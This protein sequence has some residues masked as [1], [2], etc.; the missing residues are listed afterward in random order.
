MAKDTLLL[1]Y[2]DAFKGM[3][4]VLQVAAATTFFTANLSLILTVTQA[5]T[6]LGSQLASYDTSS[7]RRVLS[8]RGHRGAVFSR[9][10]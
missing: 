8:R 7:R 4:D 5:T 2:G 10:D 9:S 1:V 3:L 6:T